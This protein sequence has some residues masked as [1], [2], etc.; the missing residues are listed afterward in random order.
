I[1]VGLI[2]IGYAGTFFG[3]IIKAAVSR[4]REFLADAS[5]VQFTRNP[6][7]IAGARKKIGGHT[8]GSRLEAEHVTED[9]HMPFDQ[10]IGTAFN[11][12]MATHPPLEA[13]I[14]RIEPRWDGKFLHANPAATAAPE[15]TA[16]SGTAANITNNSTAMASTTMLASALTASIDLVGQPSAN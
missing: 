1:G 16:S 3:N 5:A 11:A 15:Q 2:V 6:D 10:G 14:K 13:R 4:Q 9:S 8:S 7:G 12:L